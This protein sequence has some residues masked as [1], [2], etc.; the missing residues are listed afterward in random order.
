MAV[1]LDREVGQVKPSKSGLG[2]PPP[3]GEDILEGVSAALESPRSRDAA[4]FMSMGRR[5]IIV[6]G[7]YGPHDP[8]C[9]RICRRGPITSDEAEEPLAR[10]KTTSKTDVEIKALHRTQ[11][12]VCGLGV[13]VRW[14]CRYMKGSWVM[15]R[16]SYLRKKT[17]HGTEP[18]T[19]GGEAEIPG[20][21]GESL[22]LGAAFAC[23]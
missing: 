16:K 18:G 15:T 3:C 6:G 21:S 22:E 17:R 9:Y 7:P 1:R 10:L 23:G 20:I 14:Q 2:G 19:V 11:T 4:Y 13:R 5:R 8:T 12:V